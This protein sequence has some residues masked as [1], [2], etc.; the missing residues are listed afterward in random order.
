MDIKM[1]ILN[2]KLKEDVYLI[3]P[4]GFFS[5]NSKHK[6]CT[7]YKVIGKHFEHGMKRNFF[8]CK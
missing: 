7:I 1:I 4:K 3:Q 5:I 6:V 2:K 8:W